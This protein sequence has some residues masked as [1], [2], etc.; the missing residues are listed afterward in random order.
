MEAQL[1]NKVDSRKSPSRVNLMMHR[2]LLLVAA[3]LTLLSPTV[4]IAGE[5]I[6]L[7]GGTFTVLHK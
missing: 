1:G 6:E 7:T 2:N 4:V 3:L 5:Y